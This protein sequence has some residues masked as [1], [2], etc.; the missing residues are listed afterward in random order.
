MANLPKSP[1]RQSEMALITGASTGIGRA[2]AMRLARRGHPTLLVARNRELLAQV[3]AEAGR[4]APST[5]LAVDLLDD[6][7]VRTILEHLH[8]CEFPVGI[9]LNNAGIGMYRPMLEVSAREERDMFRIHYQVPSALIR[10]I[11]PGMIDR[12][13]GHVIN[14]C[15]MATKVG[16]WGHGPYAAAKCALVSLTQTLAA[17]YSS[18]GIHFSYVN[19]GI[20]NTEFFNPSGMA[21]LRRQVARYGLSADRVAKKVVGLLDRPRLEL[22]VPGHYRVL[23]WLAAFS[24]RWAHRLV[25]AKSRPAAAESSAP[26]P[27]AAPGPAPQVSADIVSASGEPW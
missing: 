26:S 5:A 8:N 10:A 7:G 24:P 20:V 13:H 1:P 15:S 2:V 4:F 16:P 11:L 6:H 3:A 17:E 12:R 27:T 21:G 19:P 9:L 22:C 14:M 18:A 25:T 23:G